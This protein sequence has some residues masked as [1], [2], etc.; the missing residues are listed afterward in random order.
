MITV[1]WGLSTEESDLPALLSVLKGHCGAGGSL[2]E[3]TIE[4]QGDHVERISGKLREI[5]YRVG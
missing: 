1:V 4:V 2:V 3:E 5:G